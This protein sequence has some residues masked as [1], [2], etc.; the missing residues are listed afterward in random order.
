MRALLILAW[1]ALALSGGAQPSAPGRPFRVMLVPSDGGTEEGTKAD[2]QPLFDAVSR[3]TGYA[4]E[5][6]V[7]QS[8]SAVIEGLAGGLVD[9][10]YVGTVAFLTAQDRGPVELLALPETEGNAYYYSGLFVR[11]D[12]PI[13]QLSDVRGRT[14]ALSDTRSSSGFVYPLAHLRKNGIEPLR[15][16][17]RIFLTGSHTNSLSA[18]AEGRVEVAAAPFESYLKAVRQGALDPRRIR[19]LAKSDPIPNPPIV[20]W[21]GL[22]PEVKRNLREALGRVHLLPG[23][24]PGMI[25]GH[26][27]EVVERYNPDVPPGIFDLARENMRLIDDDYR[28]AI[29]RRSAE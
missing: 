10:A 21:G 3:V 6:R 19:I 25:R 13:R 2:Y 5:I 20:A 28:A 1:L 14:L 12:S 27:G 29:L 7:G 23:V 17:P 26:G 15:D 9:V 24:E 8:Y 22:P 16:C 18:L 4:F 11:A